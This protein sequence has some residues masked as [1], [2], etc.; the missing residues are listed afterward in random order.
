MAR[1]DRGVT[2]PS[3]L[4]ISAKRLIK[5]KRF[6]FSPLINPEGAQNKKE[7]DNFTEDSWPGG[8]GGE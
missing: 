8:G 2:I 1:K 7:R 5:L 3:Y 4:V 6:S